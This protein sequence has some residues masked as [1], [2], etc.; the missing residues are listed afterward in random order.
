MAHKRRIAVVCALGVT[1][2]LV[3]VACAA[4]YAARQVRPFYKEALHI[5]PDA[6]ERSSRELESRASVLYS[7]AKQVGKWQALFTAQQINS[8][9]A[10]QQ[11]ANKDGELFANV[12]DVRVAVSHDCLSVGFRTKWNGVETVVSVD[13]SLLLTDDGAVGVRFLSA[14]AG[15]LP[16]PVMQVANSLASLSQKRKLPVRWTQE[17]GLPVAI[18]HIASDHSAENRQFFIDTIELRD[19][20]MYVAGHTQIAAE[21]PKRSSKL[22]YTHPAR[23]KIRLN[24]Y[25]VRLNPRDQ[26]SALE[27]ARQKHD[28]SN[29]SGAA[30]NR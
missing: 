15:A 13:A 19:G 9:F 22:A 20:E 6:M 30:S 14:R 18:I 29:G 24:D 28:T 27:I 25:E 12:R 23:D 4:Y 16:L 21:A 11:A 17:K 7:D 10:A 26:K 3:A 1:V 8:W 5:A 2:S